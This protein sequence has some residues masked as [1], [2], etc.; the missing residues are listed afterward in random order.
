[1]FVG[2]KLFCRVVL[3]LVIGWPALSAAQ[4]PTPAGDG[5]PAASA[6]NSQAASSQAANS[7]AAA[8]EKQ[9]T[10]KR[11]N[12]KTKPATANGSTDTKA[13]DTKSADDHLGQT[14]AT[15]SLP[16]YANAPADA[17]QELGKAAR[18][19]AP[20]IFQ[21]GIV[22]G[23]WGTAWVI[24]KK[25]RLLV[26]NAHVADIGSAEPGK[27]VAV[28]NGTRQFYQVEKIWYHPGVRRYVKG[29]EGI[30][31]RSSDPDEGD[32]DIRSPDLAVLQLSSE[33]PDLTAEFTPV[34]T[35]DISNLFAQPVA[36][37]GYP[38]SDNEG[39]PETG[40]TA[41][42]TFHSGV[43]SRIT[44]FQLGTGAPANEQLFVQYTMSTWGGFSGSPV[45]LPDGRVAAVHN[46]SRSKEDRVK[47]IRLIAHGIRVDCVLEMLVHHGL[48]RFVSF[49]IDKNAISVDRWVNPDPR[50][51]KARADLAR[52]DALVKEAVAFWSESKYALCEAKCNEALEVVPTYAQAFS[53][54]AA[55]LHATW[56]DSTVLTTEHSLRI[57]QAALKDSA[58]ANQLAPNADEVIQFCRIQNAITWESG[59]TTFCK[60]TLEVMNKFLEGDNLQDSHFRAT[61]LQLRANSYNL[62]DQNDLALADYSEAIR[63]DAKNPVRYDARAGF[64][65]SQEQ[66]D[67]AAADR[68]VAD[69]LRGGGVEVWWENK[70]YAATV[71]KTQ[72]AYYYIHYKGY[73]DEWDE[74]VTRNRIKFNQ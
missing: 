70:W 27:M 42:A 45:F 62:L 17:Q 10:S 65:E 44:D 2:T 30:S 23:G 73:G 72:G 25:H 60:A 3:A 19:L 15:Q 34:G 9:T 47:E 5:T 53:W 63:L 22:E 18:R 7:Q 50:T 36:I 39:L 12:K 58:R 28:Q 67:Y 57:L 52:A 6:A 51:E 64:Y 20:A 56:L 48:D 4:E 59:D 21:A 68:L 46:S 24:S 41:A 71:L 66:P 11:K 55:A 14:A 33:G 69:R 54:R 61:A 1:M 74:W 31:V 35:D 40:A 13:A 16:V 37:M 8:A 49:P 26:T 43:I 32:I 38:G 29:V